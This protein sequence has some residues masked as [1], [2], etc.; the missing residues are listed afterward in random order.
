MAVGVEQTGM[1]CGA[2]I[3]LGTE[4]CSK[5]SSMALPCS[6]SQHAVTSTGG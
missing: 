3:K 6:G 4:G 1:W 2:I 5:M